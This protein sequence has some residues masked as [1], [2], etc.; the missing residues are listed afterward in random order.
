MSAKKTTNRSRRQFLKKACGTTVGMAAGASGLTRA[1]AKTVTAGGADPSEIPLRRFGNTGVKVPILGLGGSLNLLNRQLL[2][3]QALKMGVRYWDT[4][5]NYS[6]GRSEEGIGEY[7]SKH[8]EDRKRVFLVTKTGSTSPEGMERSL[9]ASFKRLNTDYVDMYLLHGLSSVDDDVGDAT[10]AWVDKAKTDGRIRLFGF[11]THRNMAGCLAQ[12]AR[13]G[14][15]DGI[16]LTYN[17]R[18]MADDDMTQAVDACVRAGIGLIAMKTQGR[19]LS[20]GGSGRGADLVQHFLDRGLTKHQARLKAVWEN[21]QISGICSHMDNMAILK[22]NV[23]AALDRA[24]L[25]DRDRFLLDR[26]ARRTASAYCAGCGDICE[27][28]LDDAVPIADVMR[29]LMYAH[30]YN[31]YQMARDAFARLPPRVRERLLRADY[32]LAEKQCPHQ[33]AIGRFMRRAAEEM[34]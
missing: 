19:A 34:G 3:G 33:I 22:E 21:P 6:G 29:C 16:M 5:D 24:A 8:P 26:H 15:I 4:A 23:A 1:W 17:Y 2:L 13:L 32:T 30:S 11:S 25:S 28:L 10:R 7:F 14:W 27:S 9:Q 12:A 18:L 31:D 20:F